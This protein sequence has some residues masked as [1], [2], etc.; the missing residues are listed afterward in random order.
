MSNRSKPIHLR[1]PVQNGGGTEKSEA[2]PGSNQQ[3]VWN[4]EK[5]AWVT[6]PPPAPVDR[7]PD[8]YGMIPTVIEVDQTPDGYWWI[9][10]FKYHAAFIWHLKR[11][12]AGGRDPRHSRRKWCPN[13][14]SWMIH[15]DCTRTLF[16]LMKQHFIDIV[17]SQ[18]ARKADRDEL[19]KS[20][21]TS[22]KGERMRDAQVKARTKRS[23]TKKVAIARIGA[24]RRIRAEGEKE[25][26]LEEREDRIPEEV[27]DNIKY[28]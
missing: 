21:V 24:G 17:M 1:R 12:I 23:P 15:K 8:Q 13:S 27:Y 3:L 19:A 2:S 6:P 14:K 11:E 10:K 26:P 7:P 16:L 18:R 9:I 28:V 25:V 4:K 5:M 22:E 20:H